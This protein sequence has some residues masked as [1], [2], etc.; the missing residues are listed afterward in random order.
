M[1]GNEWWFSYNLHLIPYLPCYSLQASSLT[2]TMLTALQQPYGLLSSVLL[3]TISPTRIYELTRGTEHLQTPSAL[4]MKLPRKQQLLS[5]A[6]RFAMAWS[7]DMRRPLLVPH[8]LSRSGVKNLEVVSS[9]IS[10]RDSLLDVRM[11]NNYLNILGYDCYDCLNNSDM[12]RCLSSGSFSAPLLLLY[13]KHSSFWNSDCH[14][15]VC[16]DV[17]S[18]TLLPV[19]DIFCCWTLELGHF[20][21][22]STIAHLIQ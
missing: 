16:D 6:P 11:L 18:Y 19:S 7:V 20:Q 1:K 3:L 13:S 4:S 12:E 17:F 22:F 21:P 14:S 5:I 8:G 10:F 2:Y 9:Y 15:P